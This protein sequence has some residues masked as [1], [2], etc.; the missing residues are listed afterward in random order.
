MAKR[1]KIW[2]TELVEETLNN[3]KLGNPAD[4]GCFFGGDTRLRR[5]NLIFKLTKEEEEE[6]NKCAL[7]PIYFISKYVKFLTDRGETLVKLRDYQKDI[8]N[9]LTEEECRN[10]NKKRWHN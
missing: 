10:N 7:D 3:L 8:L 1:Q 9:I 4:V 2:S 6:Y 5:G